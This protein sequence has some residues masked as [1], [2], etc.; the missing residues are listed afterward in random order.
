MVN[1]ADM[2]GARDH[3]R[4]FLNPAPID[5]AFD[6]DR[7]AR[8]NAT[9]MLLARDNPTHFLNALKLITV[10]DLGGN[11]AADNEAAEPGKS[12]V[13]DAVFASSGKQQPASPGLSS[14]RWAWLYGFE[15][16]NLRD[17]LREEGLAVE[18]TVAALLATEPS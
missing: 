1:A 2:L 8:V 5:F 6:Y 15:Q 17:R 12:R 14:A 3:P 10:P 11:R 4:S 13:L 9:D 16:V 18:D 7:D